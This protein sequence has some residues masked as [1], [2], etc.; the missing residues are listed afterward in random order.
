M[1]ESRQELIIEWRNWFPDLDVPEGLT[2]WE[3]LEC[4]PQLAD[5]QRGKG[6]E[7]DFNGVY[8]IA[9]IYRRLRA[10]ERDRRRP[11]N[12]SSPVR[13]FGFGLSE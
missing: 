9:E 10:T 11:E 8:V 4:T 6:N 5:W 2:Y 7:N 1:T 3:L 12:Y 13:A